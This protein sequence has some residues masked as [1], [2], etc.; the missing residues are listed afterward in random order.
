MTAPRPSESTPSTT[1]PPGLPALRRRAATHGQALARMRALLA[2]ATQPEAVRALSGKPTDEPAIA[3]LDSWAVV[4]DTVSFYAER[5]AQE[6]FLRTATELRSVRELARTLGYELRPGVSAQTELAFTVEDAPGGPPAVTVPRGT[7]VQSIPGQGQLPQTFETG[8]DLEA[9]AAWNAISGIATV[10]Q[11]FASGTTCLWAAGT[12]TGVLPGDTVL[13][14][15]EV[16]AAPR[17][18]ADRYWDLLTVTAVDTDPPGHP[19]WTRLGVRSRLDRDG[20]SPVAALGV[21]LWAF[22]ERARLFGWNAPDPRLLAAREGTQ[23]LGITHGQWHGFGTGTAPDAD[24]VELDGDH[25]RILPGSWL[26]LEIPGQQELLRVVS[27]T[28]SGDARYGISGPLTRVKVDRT[29]HLTAFD[30]RKTVVHCLPTPLDASRM[31]RTEP[32]TGH[33]LELAAT[34]PPLPAGRQLLVQ[35]TDADSATPAV[36]VRTVVRSTADSAGTVMTVTLERSLS[37]RYLPGTLIVRGNV[38]AASHGETVEQVL[39][40]G[41]GRAAFTRLGTRRGPLTYLRAATADGAADTLELRVDGVRWTEVP[42][43]VEVGPH[44]R[45]YRLLNAEDGTA[46][47]LFGD[48][49]HGARLPTGMENVTATYRVGIGADGAMQAGQLALLPRRPLGIR[50]V[51]NPAPAH[52]WAPPEQ[53]ED[54]RRNAPLRVRTLDRAVSLSDHEDFA[55]AFAGVGAARTD[56][57]WD[58]RQILIVVSVTGSGAS[59]PGEGLL[60]DLGSALAAARD[61]GTSLLVVRGEL[62]TFGV[63]VEVQPD[64][65][66]RWAAVQEAVAAA[67]NHRFAAARQQFAT[68]ITASQVLVAVRDVPGV[69]ACTLP[70]LLFLDQAGPNAEDQG[71][72]PDQAAVAVL[73]ALPARLDAGAVRPAQLPGLAPGMVEVGVMAP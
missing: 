52:D 65:A 37:R 39:G 13:G 72:P 29:D 49:T 14:V 67:L 56:A 10:P 15:G 5:I 20:A 44:D 7:P 68:A 25:P 51:S 63:R 24:I 9:R 34:D 11:L 50:E 8:T 55:R 36:E 45:V 58:G 33:V 42:S 69:V 66:Y 1:N 26:V 54:A 57:V 35:G 4:A 60:A 46:L 18:R 41:D 62:L 61:P 31:P 12:S 59:V 38:V 48:G 6:G 40:S 21:Q 73:T 64:P 28:S 47:L 70:R 53:L 19:G 30:R 23:P 17:T 43:L 71:L 22:T 2:A 32:V 16:R 3:L 27:A